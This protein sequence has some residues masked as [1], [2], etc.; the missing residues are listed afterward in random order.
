MSRRETFRDKGGDAK[1]MNSNDLVLLP[2]HMVAL[3]YESQ[4]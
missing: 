4:S 3:N 1:S 2:V